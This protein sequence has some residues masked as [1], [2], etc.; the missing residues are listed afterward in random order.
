[1]TTSQKNTIKVGDSYSAQGVKRHIIARDGM[2]ALGARIP[3]E[4]DWRTEPFDCEIMEIQTHKTDHT[5]PNGRTTRAGSEFLPGT[6]QWGTK[7]FS[8]LSLARAQVIY[9]KLIR[10]TSDDTFRAKYERAR[11]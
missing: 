6:A 8:M 5:W 11:D 1:M 7:A 9:S 2:V 10:D 3:T 4:K